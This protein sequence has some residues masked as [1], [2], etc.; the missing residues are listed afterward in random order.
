MDTVGPKTSDR[1][2]QDVVKVRYGRLRSNGHGWVGGKRAWWKRETSGCA[3]MDTVGSETGDR[4]RKELG[5]GGTQAVALELTMLGGRQA[6]GPEITWWRVGD[7]RSGS[8]GCNGG[9]TRA[10]ALESTW[11]GGKQ[12]AGNEGA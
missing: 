5:E 7:E 12:A 10:V 11:L 2:R 9:G 8:R 3:R 6:A 4:A 1:V